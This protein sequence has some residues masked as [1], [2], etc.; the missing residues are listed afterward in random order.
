MDK[1]VLVIGSN[2]FSGAH[3]VRYALGQGCKV[4]GISRSKEPDNCFLPYKWKEVKNDKYTFTQ[5]DLNSDISLLKKVIEGF[6]PQMVVNYAAQGMVA[7]SW[8]RPADWYQTNVVAQVRLLELL[9]TLDKLERYIHFTTP[10]VYGSTNNKWVDEDTAFNPSTPY[11]VSRAACD[12]H[13]MNLY[14]V[15]GFPVIFTRA[16]NV[17]GEGQQLYRVIPRLILSA[18]TGKKFILDGGGTSTRSFI[19]IDDIS[20]LT[21]MLGLKANPGST[22]HL[23]TDSKISIRSLAGLVCDIC[24]VDFESIVEIGKE[25]LGKDETYLLSTVRLKSFLGEV[26]YIGLEEGIRRVAG[27]VDANMNTLE[28]MDWKYNHQS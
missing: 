15:Y 3:F 18:R 7:Q 6:E 1:R 16:A 19:H 28:E 23:S 4:I 22:W 13:L 20:K 14:K 11:A 5:L 26:E 21:Y 27:W 24:N 10:E 8:E 25:R 9:R 12:M 17:Y 2:S